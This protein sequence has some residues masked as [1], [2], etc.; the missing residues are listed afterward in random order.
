MNTHDES[1]NRIAPKRLRHRL[2]CAGCDEG[3]KYGCQGVACRGAAGKP[4]TNCPSA[5]AQAI[6]ERSANPSAGYTQRCRKHAA[7]LRLW[8]NDEGH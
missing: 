5:A 1:L 3:L 7:G 6:T 4:A 2:K 8:R